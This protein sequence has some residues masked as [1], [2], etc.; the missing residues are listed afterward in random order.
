MGIADD[1]KGTAKEVQG[2]I[3]G[4]QSKK[5]EG[6]ADHIRGDLKD[7]AESMLGA[8]ATLIDRAKDKL[9]DAEDRSTATDPTETDRGD[10]PAAP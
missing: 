1:V 4:D 7:A 2:A 8:A 9:H 3:T 5:A 10:R 6:Q